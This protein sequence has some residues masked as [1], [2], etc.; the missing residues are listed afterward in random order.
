MLN[1]HYSLG[2]NCERVQKVESPQEQPSYSSG[3][4]GLIIQFK[5]HLIL[6]LLTFFFLNAS[7]THTRQI[8]FEN[9]WVFL[10]I[11]IKLQIITEVID[12]FHKDYIFQISS[13]IY[14]KHENWSVCE[15]ICDRG[16]RSHVATVCKVQ[17]GVLSSFMP[18]ICC[19]K[20]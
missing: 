5:S 6:Y 2:F 12:L 7:L 10:N 9:S 8:G 4:L 20:D 17:N 3:D 14:W 11:I 18:L 13:C 1:Q 19:C 15:M 16:C